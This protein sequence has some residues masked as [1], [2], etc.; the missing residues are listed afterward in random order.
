[1]EF[2]RHRTRKLGYS[3]AANFQGHIMGAAK[4]RVALLAAWLDT[5]SSDERTIFHVA[6]GAYE[7]IVKP[8]GATGM[9]Y[10]LSFFLTA[11]LAEATGIRVEPVVGYVNDGTD[12]S[13]I[14]HAW[15]EFGAKKT[16]INL[17]Q[18]EYTEVQLTG[19]LLIL[20]REMTKGRATYSYHR[21]QNPSGAAQVKELLKDIR[22]RGMLLAKQVEH[23]RMK[24][25]ANNLDLMRDYLDAAPD[26]LTFER[27]A[28]MVGGPLHRA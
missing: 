4:Q 2:D 8:L 11:Y 22:V 27:L 15:F 28:R 7:K 20:D 12:E 13:M 25:I 21:E 16:D 5:L 3:M 9:C 18:T 1:M 23:E 17:T 19:P 6:R 10:R 14:S 26:G 24:S